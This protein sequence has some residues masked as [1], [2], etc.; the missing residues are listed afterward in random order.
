MAVRVKT[1]GVKM[2]LIC[3]D[4]GE[5]VLRAW[6]QGD[7]VNDQGKHAVSRIRRDDEG[8]TRAARNGDCA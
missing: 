8:L 5:I 4:V 7:P 2:A 3:R 1:S 6:P